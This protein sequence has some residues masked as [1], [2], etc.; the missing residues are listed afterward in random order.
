MQKSPKVKKVAE[1]LYTELGLLGIETYLDDRNER[2]GIK[3]A[4]VELVGIPHMLILGDKSLKNKEIEY[5]NRKDN[6]KTSHS[7]DSIVD[8]IQ[9]QLN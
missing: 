8:F 2:P 5:K 7:V 6:E 3:F 9:Q 4:D 1:E